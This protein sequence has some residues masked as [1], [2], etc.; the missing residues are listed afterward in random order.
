MF[1]KCPSKSGRLC[2]ATSNGK[3]KANYQPDV[4]VRDLRTTKC[5]LSLSKAC[6]E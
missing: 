4:A 3:I 1:H 2:M 5:I 6:K